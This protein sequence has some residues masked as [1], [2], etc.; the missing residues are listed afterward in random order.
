[1]FYRCATMCIVV[2]WTVM[3]ALGCG[4]GPEVVS[5]IETSSNNAQ[6]HVN[7]HFCW[8]LWDVAINTE[9]A[10]VEVVPI[11]D[12]HFNANVLR[13]L[14]PPIAP[15]QLVTIALNLGESDLAKGLITM[16]VT[17]RHPFP[18][19]KIFRGFDVRG[20]ILADGG[21]RGQYDSDVCYYAPG[22]TELTNPDGFTR[23]WNQVEFTTFGT[24]FGYTEGHFA[25][26][27]YT[28]TATL[29]PYKLF[30]YDLDISQPYYQLDPS[31]RATFP[32]MDGVVTRRYRMQ[33]DTTQ[34]PLFRFKYSID[35]SWSL[36]DPSYAPDYPVEAYDEMANCQEPYMVRVPEFIEIPYYVDEWVAGGDLEFLL[37]IGDWQATGGNVLDQISH[38]WLESPTLFEDPVDVRDTMEFVESTTDTQATYR[39]RLE[40]MMPDGLKGQQLLI[41]VES[42]WP[43]T[44]EPQ[45]D[46]DTSPFTWP[47]AP[48]AAYAVVDVPITNLTPEGDYAYVYFI[49]DWCATMRLQCTADE[50]GEYWTSGNQPLLANIM[51]QNVEGYYNDYTHVKVWQGKMVGIDS[52]S[53][54][55]FQQTC[56]DLGYS[57]ER[58]NEDY[59]DAEGCRVILV[60]GFSWPNAQPPD[61]PFT[62]EEAADMQEFIDNGGILFFMCEATRY[63]YVDGFTEL[64]EWLGMLMEYG[65]GAQPEYEDGFTRNITWHWLT[66]DVNVY[67]YFS[68]GQWIT[69][70][71]HVLTLIATNDD[72]KVV[73]MYPLPLE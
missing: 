67:H 2:F 10:E 51:S 70:D 30:A 49:P 62:Q 20:I 17:L 58:S 12:A 56:T 29:N 3:V 45:I 39:I 61:P 73:L 65:G 35:A 60:V 28:S 15:I 6:T 52:Q 59:F 66:E 31:Q 37:T 23:W 72:E 40:D 71:P 33:F 24:I 11:R 63:F 4:K 25:N 68:V 27:R 5:P 7:Q 14:Q 43:D 46:G 22:E 34:Q 42:A 48:L 8:G 16:D 13:F 26:G 50:S 57:L 55:A 32:A 47:D 18:G 44:F 53:I 21:Q 19:R 9:T 38:V 41:T 54:N 36:P 64:F 69:Q 1:M